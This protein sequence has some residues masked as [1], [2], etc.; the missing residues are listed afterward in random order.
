VKKRL[1]SGKKMAM[2]A[3]GYCIRV[4]FTLYFAGVSMKKLKIRAVESK[5]IRKERA[6]GGPE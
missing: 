4:T 1:Y 5:K 3:M 6:Q 2:R